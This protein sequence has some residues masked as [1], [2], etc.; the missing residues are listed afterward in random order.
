MHEI[1]AN[2]LQNRLDIFITG[3]IDAGELK[4]AG[5][6][7]IN[8]LWKLASDPMGPA[9]WSVA[10]LRFLRLSGILVNVPS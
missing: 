3:R 2:P 6:K 1:K 10:M 5:S 9:W 8:C 7:N 4:L